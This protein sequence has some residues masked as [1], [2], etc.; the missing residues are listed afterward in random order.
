MLGCM[1]DRQGRRQKTKNEKR[2]GDEKR[3]RD[4]DRDRE[5]CGAVISQRVSSLYVA[6]SPSSEREGEESV[7]YLG[8]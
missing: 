7:S 6:V 3:D 1:S 4:R 8:I 5:D 2:V